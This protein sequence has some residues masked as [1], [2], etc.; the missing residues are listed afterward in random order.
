MR[1]PELKAKWEKVLEIA[2]KRFD[3]EELD[4]DSLIFVIGLQELGHNY[5]KL[6]KDQKLEVMHI[7]ICKLLSRYG[8]YQY[9][10]LDKDGWPHWT[11]TEKLPYL[12]PGQQS[13]LMK[14][15]IVMYFEED[16][17]YHIQ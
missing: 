3:G 9:E 5:Q 12:K 6:K 16:L 17:K 15:A 7:G 11:A 1:T 14:E 10:G 13:V 4:L 2:A 8:Y